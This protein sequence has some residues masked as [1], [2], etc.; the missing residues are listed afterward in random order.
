MRE[1]ELTDELRTRLNGLFSGLWGYKGAVDRSWHASSY[2]YHPQFIH[3]R[4]LLIRG[5]TNFESMWVIQPTDAVVKPTHGNSCSNCDT[6]PV[7]EGE[8]ISVSPRDKGPWWAV[9]ED[10]LPAMEA[11][12]AAAKQAKVDKEKAEKAERLRQREA[13]LNDVRKS[14]Q[15]VID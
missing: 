3:R 14:L 2:C 1:I 6:M 7:V 4:G 5:Q 11:E 10:E 8:L 15:D 13:K 9:I 12:L